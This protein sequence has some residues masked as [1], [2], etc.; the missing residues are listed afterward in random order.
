MA[1]LLLLIRQQS[2]DNSLAIMPVSRRMPRALNAL[3]EQIRALDMVCV[4]RQGTAQ[5][6]KYSRC[7]QKPPSAV[8]LR[9]RNV[10]SIS[11]PTKISD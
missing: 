6:V 1:I 9:P 5:S 4:W 3:D 2:D 11:A 7:Q 10:A 8:K